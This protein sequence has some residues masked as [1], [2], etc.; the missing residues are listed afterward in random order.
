MVTGISAGDNSHMAT[1]QSV[2]EMVRRVLPQGVA[3][4]I[5]LDTRLDELGLDSLAIMEVLGAI[6]QE[7]H[8]R[9]VEESLFEIETCRDLL[10]YVETAGSPRTAT[11][12]ATA[13]AAERVSPKGATGEEI[14]PPQ[15]DVAQFPECAA[16]QE[17]LSGMAATGVE[18]PFFRAKQRVRR[19]SAT[20][21]GQPTVSYTSFDYL[22]MARSPK[23]IAA[24]KKALD[25]F[26]TSASASRLVGGNSEVLE[27]L[28]RELA[29]FLGA[30]A[31]VV[32]P[33]G[34]GTNESVLGHLF[35]PD[36]LILYDELAHRS[37]V[38]GV[39][40]SH[41]QRRPFPHNDFQFLDSLLADVRKNYRRVVVAIEGV[42]SMDGDF[43]DLPR[44]VEVKQ[45]HRALLYVDEA[46]SLGVLGA[47]GRGICEHFGVSPAQGDLWMGTISKAL[48]SAGG[49]IAGKQI[50]IEYLKYTTPSFVF[51]TAL[52]PANSAAA[53][54]ALRLLQEAP[55]RVTRL[56]DRAQRF[57]QLARKCGLNTGSSQ[58]TPVVPVIVGDSVRCVQLSAA[59]LAEGVDVQPILYPAV[60]E[61][62]S[63]LRFF[64][65]AEHTEA[66][67][68]RTVRLLRDQ[69]SKIG[70]SGK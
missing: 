40:L 4:D 11:G 44:F 26:G 41:A 38:Q 6:E 5:S 28:D 7:Y 12:S 21:A 31:A 46:H 67:I 16:F 42:Y 68:R 45:L 9:F 57:L 1:A 32:F 10:E 24:A 69:W 13:G 66:Q 29:R 52:S 17:R 54:A 55:E 19:N 62:A 56:R 14:T 63:R 64:I 51:A 18:N 60:P 35:G 36:D 25:Q 23:V 22:G 3:P 49:Y 39:L 61:S 70:P 2:I 20:I 8:V 43:P 58:A 30:E 33:S 37:I 53:L 47:A 65:T 34:F 15:Y 27:E 59:L 50:L 48:G